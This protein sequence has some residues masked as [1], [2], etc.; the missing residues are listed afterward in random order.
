MPPKRTG[1][2]IKGDERRTAL[3]GAL[4]E[5]LAER[6][7]HELGIGEI[8]ARAGLTRSAFYFYFPSKTAAVAHLLEGLG[9]GILDAASDAFAVDDELPPRDRIRRGAER[10]IAVWRKDAALYGAIIDATAVDQGLAAAW[11]KLVDDLAAIVTPRARADRTARAD[12]DVADIHGIVT[13]LLDA[14]IA[15]M[16][17]DIRAI[18]DTGRP[19]PHLVETTTEIWV[20][21][22][23]GEP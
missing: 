2:T 12:L 17:R 7:F 11:D 21:T 23:Y 6:P 8:A 10:G 14:G 4:V 16:R 13:Y 3:L 20:R 18:R 9:S 22:L 15:A 1:N 19:T 5:L